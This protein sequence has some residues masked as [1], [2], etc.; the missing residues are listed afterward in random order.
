[1][2]HVQLY[3]LPHMDVV[4]TTP[5][6]RDVTI[7]HVDQQDI[8]YHDCHMIQSQLTPSSSD[9]IPRITDNSIGIYPSNLLYAQD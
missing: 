1:M 6:G 5:L 4:M 7:D 2:E 9:S 3:C 8:M